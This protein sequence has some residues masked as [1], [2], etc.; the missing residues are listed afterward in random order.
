MLEKYAASVT[1]DDTVVVGDISTM[2]I[3]THSLYMSS[4]PQYASKT[5]VMFFKEVGYDE[6]VVREYLDSI[7]V[8]EFEGIAQDASQSSHMIAYSP[9]PFLISI[10]GDTLEDRMGIL[11]DIPHNSDVNMVLGDDLGLIV[12]TNVLDDNVTISYAIS[13]DKGFDVVVIE[14]GV[15]KNL[16]DLLQSHT[17]SVVSTMWPLVSN[18]G[19]TDVEFMDMVKDFHEDGV[20]VGSGS[21]STWAGQY[22]HDNIID[23]ENMVKGVM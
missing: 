3:I 21:V 12:V 19:V 17:P 15:V 7:E 1:S 6:E 5:T 9:Y 16:T 8:D 22:I 18:G 20:G 13:P 10:P 11:S 14:G 4:L 23:V 2:A